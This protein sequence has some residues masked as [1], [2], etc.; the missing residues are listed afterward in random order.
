VVVCFPP[1]MNLKLQGFAPKV[2][3]KLQK[4]DPA[5]ATTTP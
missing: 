1:G 5:A 2:K 3:F 4:R